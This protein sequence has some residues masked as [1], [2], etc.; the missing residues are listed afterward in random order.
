MAAREDF[1]KNLVRKI[2]DMQP[3]I[4][5]YEN[6]TVVAKRNNVRAPQLEDAKNAIVS[7][8]MNYLFRNYEILN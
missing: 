8:G 7:M 4:F 5:A 6:L 1:Y 2:A 3:A